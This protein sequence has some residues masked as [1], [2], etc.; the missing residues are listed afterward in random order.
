[1]DSVIIRLAGL[2]WIRTVGDVIALDRAACMNHAFSR[3]TYQ[4]PSTRACSTSE[5]RVVSFTAAQPVSTFSMGDGPGAAQAETPVLLFEVLEAGESFHRFNQSRVTVSQAGSNVIETG[6][7]CGPS[8]IEEAHSRI[9]NT[10]RNNINRPPPARPLHQHPR[11]FCLGVVRSEVGGG[12]AALTI[13][14]RTLIFGRN[15]GH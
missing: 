6:L 13:R 9:L 5:T 3:Y 2:A 4:V 10:V 7:E 12:R 14:S 8:R 15:N 1:M 11:P